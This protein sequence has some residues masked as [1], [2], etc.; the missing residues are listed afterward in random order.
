MRSSHVARAGDGRR[1]RARWVL[2]GILVGVAVGSLS[3]GPQAAEGERRG[4]AA[5]TP[6]AHTPEVDHEADLAL[7]SIHGRLAHQS[8]YHWTEFA[9]IVA[10]GNLAAAVGSLGFV[11]FR[12]HDALE[13]TLFV[14]AIVASLTAV[15]L[16]YFSIHVGSAATAGAIDLVEVL[17][18]LAIA[19]AQVGMFLI[20][21]STAANVDLS[22][23]ETV[24]RL[25]Y[26]LL[27]AGVFALGG[28]VANE[29]GRRRRRRWS[30]GVS[31]GRAP[32]VREPL[33]S[34]EKRQERD[35]WGASLSGVAALLAFGGSFFFVNAWCLFGAI[36]VYA[37]G[38]V[39][40]L[41]NQG[42]AIGS[43]E[44]MALAY[45]DGK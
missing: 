13:K 2:G 4:P 5:P 44:R 18:S 15:L 22:D 8:S 32:R 45:V 19:G 21:A 7:R 42:K 1:G 14:V 41:V 36:G 20:V 12:S 10:G 40:A 26:W 17:T 16:A 11:L 6:A 25:R 39:G 27:M 34:Y 23:T 24:G 3:R 31:A 33:D 28:A 9:S 30:A 38:M 29:L 43:L 37:A 35:R